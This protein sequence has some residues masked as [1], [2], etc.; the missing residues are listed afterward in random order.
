LAPEPRTSTV[1]R[2]EAK[3]AG[4]GRQQDLSQST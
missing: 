1:G 4:R 2:D 3:R